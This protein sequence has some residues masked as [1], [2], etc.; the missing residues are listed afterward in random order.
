VC[1]SV[2]I[3]LACQKSKPFINLHLCPNY[4]AGV[5]D[6]ARDVSTGPNVVPGDTVEALLGDNTS[7]CIPALVPAAVVPPFELAI[8]SGD[9][10]R[11]IAIS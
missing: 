9:S 8:G 11:S 10:V 7:P 3:M 5:G 6:C 1:A 2:C 4:S